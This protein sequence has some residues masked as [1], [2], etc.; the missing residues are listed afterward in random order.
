METKKYKLCVSKSI[1]DVVYIIVSATGISSNDC[2]DNS[3]QM[4]CFNRSH[5][6]RLVLKALISLLFLYRSMVMQLIKNTPAS[7]QT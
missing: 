6:H 1:E 5:D 3:I 7:L 2:N 4:I